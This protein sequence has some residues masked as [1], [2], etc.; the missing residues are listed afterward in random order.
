[1][2]DLIDAINRLRIDN[3]NDLIR[4]KINEGNYSRSPGDI[5]AVLFFLAS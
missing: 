3:F 1:M 2:F 4:K 5:C